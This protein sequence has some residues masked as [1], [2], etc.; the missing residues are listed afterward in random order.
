MRR[1]LLAAA[2]A[3][4]APLHAQ[5]GL[6]V[7]ASAA[8]GYVTRGLSLTSRPV[9]QAGAT[10]TVP[11]R[12]VT[13]SAGAW[14][15]LEAAPYDHAVSMTA[16]EHGPNLTELD[17]WADASATLGGVSATAGVLRLTY[18]NEQVFTPVFNTTEVYARVALPEAPLAPRLSVNYDVQKVLGAYVEAG[19][20]YS[21][22]AAGLPLSVGAV[23]AFSYGQAL[24]EGS[25]EGYYYANEGLT[26]VDV[27]VSTT[28]QA[29]AVRLSP[30]AHV[31][32]ARDELARVV[33]PDATRNA[34]A[35]VGVTASWSGA[36]PR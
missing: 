34:K 19:G 18:P 25:D 30:V 4:A 3:A 13:F 23:A 28:F 6:A 21:T 5:A 31:L 9:A 15:N 36:L 29:G 17:L 35:W 16:G 7:D 27:S 14:G 11:V 8:S 20:A 2:L 22:E 10:L 32:L 12:R 33:G 26:H 24:R 1:T